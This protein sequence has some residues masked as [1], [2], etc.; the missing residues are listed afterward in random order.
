MASKIMQLLA[1]ES[2]TEKKGTRE[3]AKF[4]VKF[5]ILCNGSAFNLCG[6]EQA[7]GGKPTQLAR[8]RALKAQN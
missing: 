7:A 1:S 3:R 2:E 5:I 8:Y 4:C 6:H